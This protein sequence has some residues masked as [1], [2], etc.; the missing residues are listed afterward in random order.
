QR[1]RIL[2]RYERT[3]WTYQFALFGMYIGVMC[4]GG[5]GWAVGCFWSNGNNVFPGAE[6]LILSPF[7]VALILSWF[8]FYDADRAATAPPPSRS[9]EPLLTALLEQEQPAPGLAAEVRP[10][11]GDRWSY[12]LFKI[13]NNLV[14]VFIPLLLLLGQKELFRLFP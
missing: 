12:V 5:W 6:L 13:R 9:P 3:R 14:L 2:R 10:V 1:E 8:C 7:L 4:L 11:F